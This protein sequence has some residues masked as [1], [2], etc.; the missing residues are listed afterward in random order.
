MRKII[1]PKF[2]S[3]RKLNYFSNF[4]IFSWLPSKIMNKLAFLV[5]KDERR[6]ELRE[7][8]D[9]DCFLCKND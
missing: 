4:L 1:I 3:E 6:S 8:G 5:E 9:E 2:L 7:G